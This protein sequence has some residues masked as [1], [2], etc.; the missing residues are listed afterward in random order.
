MIL[1]IAS[2]LLTLSV[3][4]N[5]YYL[6][7][8][9]SECRL[10]QEIQLNIAYHWFCSFE[11]GEK[12]PDHFTFSKKR[13]HK[14]N[15]NHLFQQIFLEIVRL[16]IEGKLEDVKKLAVDVSYI[17]TEVSRNSWIDIEETEVEQSML[18]Y[19]DDLEQEHAAQ[20]DLKSPHSYGHKKVHNQHNR[21]RVGYIRHG[22]KHGVGFLVGET[23]DYKHG[24]ITGVVFLANEKVFWDCGIWNG[25]KNCWGCPWRK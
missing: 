5:R 3:Y 25:R 14:W 8:I 12:I 15:E 11:L 21:S 22:S 24:I 18:S 13:T 1:Q 19:L 16:C 4:L 6:Y 23:I 2:H 20:R 7:G 9:K 17:P 10:V